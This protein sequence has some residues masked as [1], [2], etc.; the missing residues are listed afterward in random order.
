M[1]DYP[2]GPEIAERFSDKYHGS[3][4][5]WGHDQLVRA[6]ELVY[7]SKY[8]PTALQQLLDDPSQ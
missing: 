4:H 3:G 7:E 5:R 2:Q 1:A 6:V 8:V